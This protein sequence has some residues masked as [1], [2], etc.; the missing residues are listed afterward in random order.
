MDLFAQAT[1]SELSTVLGV[2]FAGFGA[3][4]VGFYKY[5]NSR[6]KE[7]EKSRTAQTVAF[8]K[9]IEKLGK[10]LSDNTTAMRAV[11]EAT[12]RSAKEAE[13]RN[14]HLAEISVENKNQIIETITQVKKQ[15]VKNQVVEHQ[16]VKE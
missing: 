5:A 4:L 2:V 1:I 7:F 9:S 3:M 10:N 6:E 12:E 11:A 16:T 13:K 14:G 8:D 15:N